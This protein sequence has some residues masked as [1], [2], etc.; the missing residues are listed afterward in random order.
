MP[1]ITSCFSHQPLSLQSWLHSEKGGQPL[2]QMIFCFQNNRRNSK[3]KKKKKSS[4]VRF[5]I[6]NCWRNIHTYTRISCFIIYLCVCFP[7]R[8]QQCSPTI[9]GLWCFCQGF[10]F[11]FFLKCVM[12][13]RW[14]GLNYNG[15]ENILE[16]CFI[17][18]GSESWWF[19]LSHLKG[20]VRHKCPPFKSEGHLTSC[21]WDCRISPTKK[22]IF[23]DNCWYIAPFFPTF[24]LLYCSYLK[25]RYI[26]KCLTIRGLKNSQ[27]SSLYIQ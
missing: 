4:D 19:L 27:Q 22:T 5:Q 25:L 14:V 18:T 23:S 12:I 1:G 8:H 11:F 9:I 26:G 17:R 20:N 2:K 24:I 7:S 6:K 16:K 13:W 3:G 21:L 15:N 10:F